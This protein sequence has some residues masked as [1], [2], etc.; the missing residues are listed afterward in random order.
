M[1]T[2]KRLS[3]V[4]KNHHNRKEAKE[5]ILLFLFK[6]QQNISSELQS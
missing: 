1:V 3:N 6:D 4:Q 5:R 2:S